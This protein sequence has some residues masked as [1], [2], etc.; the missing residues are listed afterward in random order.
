MAL[1]WC[2]E[3]GVFSEQGC[4]VCVVVPPGVG[5]LTYDGSRRCGCPV[6]DAGVCRRE[7]KTREACWRRRACGRG[8]L[9][10]LV[11]L[12]WRVQGGM[13]SLPASQHSA[14]PAGGGRGRK[15]GAAASRGIDAADVG[16]SVTVSEGV[17]AVFMR[18]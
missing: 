17:G 18:E 7:G 6:Q 16:V 1:M 5:P 2:I 13:E 4:R 9:L 10:L 14:K 3:R 12:V 11:N 15:R 8:A